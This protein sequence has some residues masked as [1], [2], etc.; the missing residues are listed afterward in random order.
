MKRDNQR[1]MKNKISLCGGDKNVKK[2]WGDGEKN[3]ELE[4]R[5]TYSAKFNKPT[6]Q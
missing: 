1:F 6:K 4:L 2:L 5:M 3:F